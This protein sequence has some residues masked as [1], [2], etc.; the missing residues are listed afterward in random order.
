[1]IDQ[2]GIEESRAETQNTIQEYQLKLQRL[3]ERNQ[4]LEQQLAS[5]ESTLEMIRNSKGWRLLGK[6]REVKGAAQRVYLGHFP[7]RVLRFL[8]QVLKN[9]Y[10]TWIKRIEQPGWDRDKITRSINDFSH[11]PKTSILMPVYNTPQKYLQKAIAS[12][13]AQVYENWELCIC[14]DGSPEEGVR[15]DLQRYSKE[16]NR[17]IVYFSP[18]NL[19]IS[20]AS[21]R[22]LQ[23]ASGEFVGLLDHDDELSPYALYEVVK[24]LQEFPETDLIYSDEDKLGPGEVRTDPFFKPEWSPEYFLSCMYICH[25]GVYRRSILEEIGGFRRGFEGSQDYDLALRFTERTGR[26][27]HIP[28][29]LY[30]WRMIPGSAAGSSEAKPYAYIAAKKALAE[31]LQRTGREGSIIDGQW[32]GHYRAKFNIVNTDKVS[33]IIP[34]RDRVQFLKRCITSIEL[35]TTYQN[36]EILIIDNQSVEPKTCEYLNVSPH[37]VLKFPEQFNFS[38]LINFGVKHAQGTYLLFLNNDTEVICA[39]WLSAMLEFCQQKEVGAVGA[40]LLFPDNRIQHIGV[41]LGLGGVAGH[42]FTGF[43]SESSHYF[44]TAG[45]IRNYSA[46]TAAC[47]MV[48]KQVFEQVGGFDENLSVAYNDVDFCL[49][50]RKAG[51]RIVAT[52]YAKLYHYESASR[53]YQIDLREVQYMRRRWGNILSNDPYYNPNLILKAEGFSIRL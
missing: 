13:Q 42:P 38:R 2:K 23:L 22:A 48:R 47:M 24:L 37:R 8:K 12:V 5:A 34:T 41:V 15:A 43:P 51:Y 39:E 20:G 45:D 10:E 28:K 25:F 44:G 18:E 49:R 46:V 11:K 30:H 6:Y 21:N 32:L 31:H 29:V 16:D 1:M 33:I 4:E 52:P 50:I 27:R 19:G 3:M 14:D 40:K 7:G 26:I 36:Y 9:D 35:K 53:G 17:I